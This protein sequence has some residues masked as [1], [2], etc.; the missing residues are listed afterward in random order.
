M[1]K[2][3]DESRALPT[4]RCEEIDKNQLAKEWK[5][6]KSALEIYFDAYD[7]S[8]QRKMRA[9]LLHLGGKQLQRVYENLP[10][11]NKIPLVSTKENWYDV[12]VE[13][14]DAYFEPGRQYI[15][16]RCRLRKIKQEK[17]ERF[18]H[19][20]M[21][22]R[23]QLSDC[24]F[25]KYSSEVK[26]VLTELFVIDTIVEGCLSDELRR[27]ILQNDRSLSEIVE[28]GAMM[29]GVE[30]QIKDIG[31]LNSTDTTEKVFQV[32]TE[33]I[34]K[35]RTLYTE[36]SRSYYSSLKPNVKSFSCYR[37]GTQGHVG[38][39]EMCKARD[40]ICRRCKKV[41]HF[42]AVCRT[43]TYVSTSA[44]DVIKAKKVHLVE[45]TEAH[46]QIQNPLEHKAPTQS[47]DSK[48]YYC[49][50]GGN[51]S[52]VIECKIGGVTLELLVDSGSD[53]N[54]IHAEAW[55]FLKQRQVKV[56]NMQKGSKQIIKGYGSSIPLI[57]I[58]TFETE[59]AIGSR[60]I[61]TTFYVVEGG[62]RCLLG[63]ATAKELGILKIGI[64]V[65]Q[66]EQQERPFGKI[67]DVQVHIHMDP[68]FKP[69]F[70]PV[71]RVPI[72]YEAAVNK[73]LDILLAQDIIEVKT[74]PTTWVS[75]LVVVGKANGEPRVCLDLRRVNEAV[76]RERFPMPIVDEILARIGKGKVRSKLDIRDAF[77][78]T[79]LA[80][81]SRDITTFITN[82]GLFRFKR[83]P[84]G[85]VSAPEIFQKV[86]DE[87]LSGCE[88]TVCY[89]DDI[90]VEGQNVEEHDARLTKV[91]DRLHARGVVL[92]L[93]KCII[94][95]TELQFL[96]HIIS[97]KGLRP[98]PSK[99]EALL[100]FRRPENVS[101]IKSFLGLANYMNKFIPN[102]AAVDEP[103]R[104]LLLQSS[105]FVWNQEQQ[106]AFDIIKQAMTK[107]NNL[108]YFNCSD[109]TSVIADASP[110][111]LGAALIQTNLQ[112][113]NC[114]ICFASK[115]LTETER[116][117][118]DEELRDRDAIVKEK[119]K[120]YSDNRRQAKKSEV[121]VGDRVLSKRFRKDNK[122]CT[123]F[124]NEEFVV[125]TKTGSDTTIKS[126]VSGKEY[127]RNTS[128]LKKIPY[129]TDKYNKN[130]NTPETALF[131]ESPEKPY[132]T[133]TTS[134]VNTDVTHDVGGKRRRQ[135][136][137][138][139]RSYVP[140]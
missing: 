7:V 15:L 33:R 84:F 59:I 34:V 126:T 120:E 50:Y 6:W 101:E 77:L 46:Q 82:R 108:G 68:S 52:N 61:M 42:E 122:L 140:Y 99:V 54:V 92:N 90:Y 117:R 4:F 25:E 47:N 72:P 10:D 62:Q 103:L 11:N 14:L 94:R 74:G 9:K 35:N 66:V 85:L 51:E 136:P 69:V 49:F 130:G 98:S 2:I 63:D 73:K 58:G 1:E 109:S 87:I 24:G 13:K 115:S 78:Q 128:H 100:S 116:S 16:E 43:R 118:D 18:S 29:E 55:T 80:P 37:C 102:L 93:Q 113:E 111:A 86:M 23:Q 19:F 38:S 41:G 65:N 28:M 67:K 97:Q 32:K 110:T 123:E 75:P 119:G 17:N 83:L 104:K 91:F 106:H 129:E 40:Q 124:M 12:A 131:S 20:V 64:D 88:G 44:S 96:G 137:S 112:G 138:W 95:V 76:I 48:V 81:E 36:R 134:S 56:A 39:S 57:I 22:I 53:I 133:N 3:I 26:D 8:D 114:V 70:Q 31:S 27:R 79:E 139:F 132:S 71:R 30:Q 60:S 121:S 89:L 127:R 5:A 125:L 107:E 105:K 135:E 45:R 21:R